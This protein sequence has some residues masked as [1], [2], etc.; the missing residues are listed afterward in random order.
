LLSWQLEGCA[1]ADA[2]TLLIASEQGDLFR[3]PLA[4]LGAV[5]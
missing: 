1:W 2:A 4:K 3:L 5:K